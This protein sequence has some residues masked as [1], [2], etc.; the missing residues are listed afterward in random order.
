MFAVKRYNNPQGESLFVPSFNGQ[1]SKEVPDG[2]TEVAG[3]EEASNK[4]LQRAGLG[5]PTSREDIL[6]RGGIDPN[7]GSAAVLRRAGLEPEKQSDAFA[8]QQKSLE[9]KTTVQDQTS[10]LLDKQQKE[11]KEYFKSTEAPET[12]TSKSIDHLTTQLKS[13]YAAIQ[14]GSGYKYENEKELDLIF[15]AQA[16][17]LAVNGINDLRDI[18][19]EDVVVEPTVRT[20]R[21]GE[22]VNVQKDG[23]GNYFY[24]DYS[25]LDSGSRVVIPK[26]K[27]KDVREI[28]S[29]TENSDDY[30]KRIEVDILEGGGTERYLINKV[31]GKRLDYIKFT[32]GQWRD[33]LASKG[34]FA[35]SL[36]KSKGKLP[37]RDEGGYSR[38]GHQLDVDGMANYAAEFV[39]GNFVTMPVWQ[40]TKTDL[41]PLMMMASIAL[42]AY[43]VPGQIGGA[44]TPAGTA[45]GTQMAVGN[46]VIAGGM[47]AL[48]GGDLE[49]IAKSAVLSG[50]MTYASA[51]VPAISKSIGETLLGPGAPGSLTVGTAITNAGINGIAAALMGQDV[52]KA[53]LAGSV[54]GAV[55]VNASDFLKSTFGNETFKNL[56]ETLNIKPEDMEKVV[57]RSLSKGAGAM[58][59][60]KNFFT[61]F[62]DS[63]VTEG[64]SLSA[65]NTA[66]K[67]MAQNPNLS[68][69]Q[70]T[71]IH[72]TV[73]T[74]SQ[75]TITAK[76]R[77]LNPATVLE[78]VYPK[79]ILD[80]AKPVKK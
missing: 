63:L 26:D 60:N 71:R 55:Q 49:D 23:Q 21:S 54:Q 47:T 18:G 13:Q 22:G 57:I 74:V 42:A 69:D 10:N 3:P 62:R 72:R 29:G 4:V 52:G 33:D 19:Y 32:S 36:G 73:R 64:F 11:L 1:P 6:R 16:A 2:F 20:L 30:S 12:V 65:A 46:A 44:L 79:I 15:S 27:I 68:K 34:E 28:E 59:Y 25:S 9:Q 40:D 51:Y 78:S 75:V 37:L 58:A 41:T 17:K 56:S 38:W 39:D 45:A 48:S 70:L 7:E 35:G 5:S 50:G 67:A 80:M 43:G 61:T 76:Q 31:T 8:Q 14:N 77:G 66:T 24:M 53:M